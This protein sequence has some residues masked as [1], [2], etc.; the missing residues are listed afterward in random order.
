MPVS[1][2][3]DYLVSWSNLSKDDVEKATTHSASLCCFA[4]TPERREE[5]RRAGVVDAVIAGAMRDAADARFG[6]AACSLLQTLVSEDA[7]CCSMVA[8]GAGIMLEHILRRFAADELAVQAAAAL[9][10]Q[11]AAA[12][13]G[14][15]NGRLMKAGLVP[16]LVDLLCRDC[17]DAPT[18]RACAEALFELSSKDIDDDAHA[19]SVWEQLAQPNDSSA[20]ASEVGSEAA[21]RREFAAALIAAMRR[22]EC[23]AIV[24]RGCARA[25]QRLS[26]FENNAGCS[27]RLQEAG[28]GAVLVA[29]M[30]RHVDEDVLLHP[31]CA[32]LGNLALHNAAVAKALIETDNAGSALVLV[33]QR[34][35]HRP[36]L[37][38]ECCDAL[39]NLAGVDTGEGCK[40][41]LIENDEAGAAVIDA[42]QRHEDNLALLQSSS[43]ALRR[44][45]SHCASS[46]L[47]ILHRLGAGAALAAAM[48]SHAGDAS[49]VATCCE[50]LWDLTLG[51]D[52]AA[53]SSACT[54]LVTTD[55]AAAALVEAM[56][57]HEADACV[58]TAAAGALRNFA[59]A[60]ESSERAALQ[61]LCA[62]AA[63]V[64]AM[65]RHVDE[66]GL[67]NECCR[68]LCN[69]GHRDTHGTCK[70]LMAED[71]VVAPLLEAMGRHKGDG[72]VLTACAG[73]FFYLACAID[74]PSRAQLQA[75]GVGA[76]LIEAMQRHVHN[77]NLVEQCCNALM[78]I[79]RDDEGSVCEGLVT[80]GVGTALVEAMRCHTS[81]AS[82][83]AACAGALVSITFSAKR[84]DKATLQR[85][86]AGA[87]LAAII[88]RPDL[89]AV[90]IQS[91]CSAMWNLA[92][93]DTEVARHLIAEDGVGAA[94]AAALRTHEGDLAVVQTCCGALNA[95]CAHASA[96]LR[97]CPSASALTAAL[98]PALRRHCAAE[99][100]LEDTVR[101]EKHGARIIKVLAGAAGG[102]QAQA[103]SSNL[104]RAGA[105]AVLVRGILRKPEEAPVRA[106]D[107]SRRKSKESALRACFSAVARLA[108]HASSRDMLRM[109][110]QGAADALVSWLL[111]VE[112]DASGLGG[113]SA[114]A[115][116]A[117]V[118]TLRRVVQ[119]ASKAH[120]PAAMHLLCGQGVATAVT[121]VMC[122]LGRHHVHSQAKIHLAVFEDGLLILQLL[123][124][125][126]ENRWAMLH[127]GND[128]SFASGEPAVLAAIKSAEAYRCLHS[129]ASSAAA[130]VPA[131]KLRYRLLGDLALTA[132]AGQAAR[133][134]DAFGSLSAAGN[135]S[136]S[137]KHCSCPRGLQERTQS[138]AVGSDFADPDIWSLITIPHTDARLKSSDAGRTM[139]D[140]IARLSLAC[141]GNAVP[142]TI[143]A[144]A[145]SVE[146]VVR[147]NHGEEYL[148]ECSA[149]AAANR[150]LCLLGLATP[151]I[152][153]SL[154]GSE[155]PPHRGGRFR[156][157]CSAHHAEEGESCTAE[158]TGGRCVSAEASKGAAAVAAGQLLSWEQ[159]LEAAAAVTA[160]ARRLDC[161]SDPTAQ[162]TA[163]LLWAA[164]YGT[165]EAVAD[166]VATA[167]DDKGVHWESALLLAAEAGRAAAVDTLLSHR[168]AFKGHSAIT[169]TT[170]NAA[171]RLAALHG[172]GELV[173]YL[174]GYNLK[175]RRKP[176]LR[177][178]ADADHCLALC[179]AAEGGH[180][181]IVTRLMAC[182]SANPATCGCAP[183]WL[184][185]S[186][187]HVGVVDLLLADPRCDAAASS[188]AAMRYA[189]R[190]GHAAVVRRLLAADTV[191]PSILNGDELCSAVRAGHVGVLQ[192]L[193]ADPRVDAMPVATEQL[194][195]VWSNQYLPL[196]TALVLARQPSV[197]RALILSG[198]ASETGNAQQRWAAAKRF[199]SADVRGWCSDAWR[200]RRH[201][202]LARAVALEE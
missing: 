46:S 78:N 31:C 92:C 2:D 28:M 107:W 32:A 20:A 94:L 16:S 61:R 189:C 146:A 42:M 43:A 58:V 70:R 81:N 144:A 131:L 151:R 161:K 64:S 73:A 185:A 178:F 17:L 158:L 188:H 51:D 15:L 154:A 106:V 48:R 22:H 19:N 152:G 200:R 186:N 63:L 127:C 109:L 26:S 53:R 187:G 167:G 97:Q 198:T 82:T 65:R 44:L 194:V 168:P 160:R 88:Q 196:G 111:R 166:A 132:A 201:V 114:E 69:I 182:K 99:L 145:A 85:Q 83:L 52:Y 136:G 177:V 110:E 75:A 95:L 5:L 156:S 90:T 128:L 71:G 119:A 116:A 148:H 195:D 4:S 98:V 139:C 155:S 24:L 49:L 108:E 140:A 101:A 12:E 8:T 138:Q 47:A 102:E 66:A 29:T 181:A 84:P 41:V 192:A 3:I 117:A 197:V 74:G 104:I 180:P 21:G 79:A 135:G 171:M 183:L 56:R 18:A 122:V 191:A 130:V 190:G 150:A 115:M 9:V 137:V 50:A 172:H 193:L 176:D 38:G 159:I 100:L 91:G 45:A 68:A 143:S 170:I 60:C 121:T 35:G 89:D 30:H 62:G 96:Q 120:S 124:Q 55:G 1:I 163:L 10:K 112:D 14:G 93:A 165:D 77:S 34:H 133:R 149:M 174:L 157:V 118:K 59:H 179:M 67:V 199:T 7:H 173:E 86:G 113:W 202:V 175:H 134:L 36:D 169:V 39:W 57:R 13:A 153:S 76:A 25:A 80:D 123:A 23:D 162:P 184:A 87:A 54:K 37:L 142:R 72:A 105:L 40:R 147:Q 11:L 27:S 164:L 126:P 125:V 103:A 33:M 141:A 6:R 129:S